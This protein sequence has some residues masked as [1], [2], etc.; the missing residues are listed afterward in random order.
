MWAP[1]VSSEAPHF[2]QL[3]CSGRGGGLQGGG[4]SRKGD[5]C[6]QRVPQR[7]SL[8]LP[9][10]R[11]VG[12][13]PAAHGL[14]S[15]PRCPRVSTARVLE[16]KGAAA[17]ALGSLPWG[18]VI[19]VP[20]GSPPLLRDGG[21]GPTGLLSQ[22][23]GGHSGVALRWHPSPMTPASP[24]AGGRSQCGH[25]SCARGTA[26]LGLRKLGW[27]LSKGGR[28]GP[29]RRGP[30]RGASGGLRRGACT[31]RPVWPSHPACGPGT[32]RHGQCVRGVR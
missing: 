22:G 15:G 5:S 18:P 29:S 3:T 7:D 20:G 32:A 4:R 12:P 19:P 1:S 21:P 13:S 2:R 14:C 6:L 28:S 31:Q 8:T 26:V 9:M 10:P 25:G 17:L 11:S 16:A 23:R 24:G 27:G 30:V